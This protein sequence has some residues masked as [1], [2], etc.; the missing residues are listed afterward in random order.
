MLKFKNITKTYGSIAAL[1]DISFNVR[2]GDFVFITGPSGAGKTTIL[3]LIL[4]ETTPDEGSIQLDDVDI[5]KL[6][7]KN[8]PKLRQNI[9]V[10]F[11]DFKVLP[12]RTV[13]ENVSIALAV[14]GVDPSEWND[15]VEEVLNVT[16]LDERQNLFPS[17]LSGGELQRVSL[18]RA[19]VVNPKIVLADEPTGNLDWDTADKIMDLFEKVNDEGKT[20]IVATHHKKIVEKSGKRVITLDGGKIVNDTNPVKDDSKQKK[21]KQGQK[22]SEPEKTDQEKEKK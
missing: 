4:R 11:Q 7:S 13:K 8:I 1:T 19:L 14:C 2:E 21:T 6:P 20:L 5:V 17:Q 10:V 12:E 15:R 18:A 3:K 16:G 9:G 22:K